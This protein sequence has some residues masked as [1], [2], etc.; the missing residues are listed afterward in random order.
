MI[1]A[2]SKTST[3]KSAASAC[4]E[5]TKTERRPLTLHDDS[6]LFRAL[7]QAQLQ[8][9]R[10]DVAPGLSFLRF[11]EA[12][13]KHIPQTPEIHE[14]VQR[15]FDFQ[16]SVASSSPAGS[17]DRAAS[18]ESDTSVPSSRKPT[19]VKD[20]STASKLNKVPTVE[21]EKIFL[22]LTMQNPGSL[23]RIVQRCFRIKE[24][25]Q[26]FY[27]SGT[28]LSDETFLATEL[29]PVLLMVARIRMVPPTIE[30]GLRLFDD[31]DDDSEQ[32]TQQPSSSSN[33]SRTAESR[34]PLSS[35]PSSMPAADDDVTTTIRVVGPVSTVPSTTASKLRA[36]SS[37]IPEGL[38][39]SSV[40]SVNSF[41]DSPVNDQLHTTATTTTSSS[42]D[43]NS[44]QSGALPNG[45][46]IVGNPSSS[47]SNNKKTGAKGSH[48]SPNSVSPP[49][50]P[51]APN[52]PLR[53]QVS[54]FSHSATAAAPPSSLGGDATP[55]VVVL[56]KKKLSKRF[57]DKATQAVCGLPAQDDHR[58]NGAS[59][60]VVGTLTA[61]DATQTDKMELRA[62][63]AQTVTSSTTAP[64]IAA[65][66]T[67]E[68]MLTAAE[69][70]EWERRLVAKERELT[71][72]L[73]RI[74]AMEAALLSTRRSAS[75]RSAPLLDYG[76]ASPQRLA[77]AVLE[78]A[79][80]PTAAEPTVGYNNKTVRSVSP[81]PVIPDSQ[82][83][84]APYPTASPKFGTRALSRALVTSA[85]PRQ[86]SSSQSLPPTAK[87][88]EPA[89][90]SEES[91]NNSNPA[92]MRTAAA[93]TKPLA[94]GQPSQKE[95]QTNFRRNAV[96]VSPGAQ[97]PQNAAIGSKNC[98]SDNNGDAAPFVQHAPMVVDDDGFYHTIPEEIA[99][100]L[101]SQ[102]YLCFGCSIPLCHTK[103]PAAPPQPD[104]THNMPRPSSTPPTAGSGVDSESLSLPTVEHS[105]SLD[106]M[107]LV[108]EKARNFFRD[109]VATAAA[110]VL[111]NSTKKVATLQQEVRSRMDQ[112]RSASTVAGAE[113]TGGSQPQHID[114]KVMTES[115]H[116]SRKEPPRTL[117]NQSIAS[118]SSTEA[119]KNGKQEEVIHD[120]G[121][122]DS[123]NEASS[124]SSID[125]MLDDGSVRGGSLDP[126]EHLPSSATPAVHGKSWEQCSYSGHIFCTDCL[127]PDSLFV[128]PFAVLQSQDISLYPMAPRFLHQITRSL[129]P[130]N[131]GLA[132]IPPSVLQKYG[133]LVSL[134]RSKS[135]ARSVVACGL[136]YQLHLLWDTMRDCPAAKSQ[137]ATIPERYFQWQPLLRPSSSSSCSTESETDDAEAFLHF[138]WTMWDLVSL[139]WNPTLQKPINGHTLEPFRDLLSFLRDTRD[140]MATHCAWKCDRC[141]QKALVSCSLC[142]DRKPIYVFDTRNIVRCAK[143][144]A[145]VHTVCW[146][147][148][149]Q[150]CSKCALKAL[151]NR[152]G[153]K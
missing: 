16:P 116:E 26:Q 36:G 66:T 109:K 32:H 70:Q 84:S 1:G 125:E 87:E 122:S 104:S 133:T 8:L 95:S 74:E 30:E 27:H 62:V 43:H 108:Q 129:F 76:S 120:D 24:V 2:S 44:K 143:C 135:H 48:G 146:N 86:Q 11:F 128:L 110:E 13:A 23:V 31:V 71:D 53:E 153:G 124:V 126:I 85:R 102:N 149:Q 103:H 79:G 14:I 101:R 68:I 150:Q 59:V 9:F 40:S 136:R 98:D 82:P 54:S 75:R 97:R 21:R 130:Y 90:R 99:T 37:S 10:F 33:L 55:T 67:G 117:S 39:S 115:V 34:R 61:H 77:G 105:S 141:K 18:A 127:P 38:S 118:S 22:L 65:A 49:P 151:T 80:S 25:V 92:T 42:V 132:T 17:L 78:S 15:T 121:T 50:P 134:H 100:K 140:K 58:V 28:S 41:L 113:E 83:P 19:A 20:A 139:E 142:S 3:L 81:V 123:G 64:P 114:D 73:H 89:R 72:R 56:T 29:L 144:H 60:S 138:P 119:E 148:N 52:S 91:L 12:S 107:K 94:V 47:S 112:R 111:H 45:N 35:Q 4:V 46:G 106:K 88:E 57:V 147:M 7:L 145:S 51:P 6:P 69:L 63:G 96:S 131:D 137:L 93:A 152:T 5:R